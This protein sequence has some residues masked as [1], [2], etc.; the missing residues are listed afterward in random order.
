MKTKIIVDGYNVLKTLPQ[1]SVLQAQSLQAAR[2]ALVN[3]LSAK[4]HKY[5]V[6]VVFDAWE[7]LSP[8][9]SARREHGVRVVYSRPGERAD[10]LIARLAAGANGGCV[11]VTRDNAIR[12][13]AAAQGCQVADPEALL[14]T[15]RPRRPKM[16][17]DYTGDDETDRSGRRDSKKGPSHRPKK[18]RRRPEWRF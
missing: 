7:T 11:I 9:E 15:P 13:F 1:Y 10:D 5:D 17:G 16:A 8:A 12:A 4:A 14:T 2:D 18:Q 3:S 6:T